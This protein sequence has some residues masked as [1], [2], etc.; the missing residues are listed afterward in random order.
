M[1]PRTREVKLLEKREIFSK[2]NIEEV[3]PGCIRQK[4]S[5]RVYPET[6]MLG[7]FERSKDVL[8]PDANGNLCEVYVRDLESP[9][10]VDRQV[11][12]RVWGFPIRD[13]DGDGFPDQVDMTRPLATQIP[14]GWQLRR[15]TLRVWERSFVRLRLPHER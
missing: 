14:E 8:L 7:I 13:G 15:A 9:V 10:G 11:D 5:V 3:T 1:I 4:V 6:K 12:F 2:G